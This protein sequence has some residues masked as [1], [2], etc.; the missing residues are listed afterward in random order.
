MAANDWKQ[1]LKQQQGAN[2]PQ[3]Q[4]P[5]LSGTDIGSGTAKGQQNLAAG[6]DPSKITQSYYTNPTN[7]KNYEKGRP[8]YQQ[9][10]AVTDAANA[11]KTH[12]Q[13]N[14][15]GQYQSTWD[16]EIQSLINQAMTRPD[17]QYNAETDPTYQVYEDKFKTQGRMA[18]KGATGEA[19]ATM[20]GG[21]ANTY[22]QQMGQEQ[23]QQYMQQLNETIPQLREQAFE[24]YQNENERMRQNLGMLQTEEDRQYG[25]YRDDVSDYQ[26]ELNYLYTMFNDM[27][28]QEYDRYTNDRQSWEADRDYWYTK[29]YNAQQLAIQQAMLEKMR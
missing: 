22:A 24:R 19:A 2:A 21:Y 12:Q 23:Y 1:M 14:K 7:S 13:Q 10:Q 9:S 8:V 6:V 17:F 29:W 5:A 27:S 26:S 28:Q 18:Q 25:M 11:L 20:T 16:D 3:A 15:P 4:S